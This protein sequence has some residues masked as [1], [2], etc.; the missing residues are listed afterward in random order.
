VLVS[1][2]GLLVAVAWSSP[3][4]WLLVAVNLVWSGL[5]LMFFRWMGRLALFCAERAAAAARRE[6]AAVEIDDDADDELAG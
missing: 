2:A 4:L 6:E 1:R 5:G 3:S